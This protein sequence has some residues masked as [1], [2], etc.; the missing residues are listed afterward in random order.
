MS[1]ELLL[2]NLR[3]EDTRKLGCRLA[4]LLFPGAFLAL[5]GGL[6]AGKTTLAR[7]VAQGLGIEGIISPTFTI[8]REYCGRLPLTHFDAYRL[9]SAQELYDI[10][11]EDY[12]ERNGVVI[13]EWSENVRGALPEDRLEITISGDGDTPRSMKL[14]STGPRHAALL[15]ALT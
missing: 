4:A 6:G 2:E 5:Y 1:A 13:M 7:A 12:L 10:G 8:A 9:S 15:E 11:F 3:E 14:L